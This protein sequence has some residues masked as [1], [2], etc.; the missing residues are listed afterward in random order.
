MIPEIDELARQSL[1]EFIR[2]LFVRDWQGRRENE[3]RSLYAFG[4]LAPR[5]KPGHFLH[6]MTQIA[7]DV[8]VPQI[9]P[10]IQRKLRGSLKP[11]KD[12]AKDLIIWPEAWMTCWKDGNPV[13]YPSALMEWKFN[14]RTVSSY[15]VS[16]LEAFSRGHREFVGYALSVDKQRRAFA[17]S[18]TRV[19]DG[20]AESEWLLI[21]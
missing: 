12:V 13:H 2:D 3:A 19:Y 6:D 10:E 11:K 8:P 14:T 4:Y 7:L 21:R 18:C 15:D 17:L 16:W 1:K 9:D 5:C 20:K